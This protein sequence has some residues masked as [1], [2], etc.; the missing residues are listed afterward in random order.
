MIVALYVLM[1]IL[2]Y[3]EHQK[4]GLLQGF[5]PNPWIFFA[6]LY[7]ELIFRGLILGALIQ[8]MSDKKAIVASSL[9]FALWH[10]KN[11]FYLDPAQLAYQIAYAG[12]LIGP[13]LAYITLKTKTVWPGIIL[14]Y[15]NNLLSPLS[16]VALGYALGIR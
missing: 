13:L 5:P 15:L 6:P 4:T 8:S 7:E 1:V 12:F 10:L 11:V 16:W 9:L 2:G 3:F 14:H